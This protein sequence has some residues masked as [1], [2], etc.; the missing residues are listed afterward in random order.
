MVRA[1]IT[2]ERQAITTATARQ[3]DK[4]QTAR[5]SRSPG[6]HQ[7]ATQAPEGEPTPSRLAA[8]RITAAA[9]RA[10]SSIV[11]KISFPES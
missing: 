1:A 5:R 8:K 3:P 2:I 6:K 7:L 11:P 4:A 9:R 10:S